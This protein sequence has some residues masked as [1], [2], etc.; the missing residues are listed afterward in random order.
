MRKINKTERKLPVVI[1]NLREKSEQFSF[2]VV[3]S[4]IKFSLIENI[5]KLFLI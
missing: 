2:F 4:R 5:F 1:R 3:E